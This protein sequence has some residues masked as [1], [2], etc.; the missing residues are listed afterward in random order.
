MKVYKE[1]QFLVFDFEDGKT[2]KYDFA[3]KQAIGKRGLPV[4]NLCSQLKDVTV[5]DIIE[6]C[7]DNNYGHFLKFIKHNSLATN[8]GTLLEKTYKFSA[9]EPIFSAGVTNVS[10]DL[11]NFKEKVPTN[12]INICK[13]YQ[14]TLNQALL[15]SYNNNPNLFNYI[16]NTEFSFNSLT[17]EDLR[18]I[19]TSTDIMN[20]QCVHRF[21]Y[22][23]KEHNYNTKSLLAYFDNLMTF[24]ALSIYGIMNNFYDY[25]TMASKISNKFDKYPKNLLTTHAI[26]VRNYNRLKEQFDEEQFLKIRDESLEMQYKDYIMIYPKSTQE[27]KDEAV[28]QHN[29][30]ASYIKKVLNG[31][32][33]IMF[34]RKKDTPS[35]S[36]VTIE[37]RDNKVVQAFRSYNTPIT[38]E[39]K[40]FIDRWN[41]LHCKSN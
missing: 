11:L 18:I 17:L 25:L 33:H 22:V 9:Y 20:Q 39:D 1:R 40:E 23:I 34:L 21:D 6:C 36:L 41:E 19:I 38:V 3:K 16:F 24:E 7:V 15:N 10:M 4:A 5:D 28:Q 30:V 29:C 8:I 26:T 13:K 35:K 32:C 37:I 14:I 31:D 12:L 27:I 2:V